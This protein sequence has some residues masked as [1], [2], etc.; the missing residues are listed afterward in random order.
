VKIEEGSVTVGGYKVTR[1]TE[2]YKSP[3]TGEYVR[4][5]ADD[6]VVG[7]S[8]D[9]NAGVKYCAIDSISAN[10][11]ATPFHIYVKEIDDRAIRLIA[12]SKPVPARNPRSICVAKVT[13]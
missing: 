1:M 12:Q 6:A 7:F 3:L 10:N 2:R 9:Q 13:A 8:D 4:K 5:V 11:A